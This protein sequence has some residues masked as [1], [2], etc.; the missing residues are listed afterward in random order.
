MNTSGWPRILLALLC[1]LAL[2]TSA[3]AECAWVLWQH[4]IR[5]EPQPQPL[6]TTPISAYA[7]KDECEQAGRQEVQAAVAQGNRSS[8]HGLGVRIADVIA[9]YRCLP[10]PWTR[11]GRREGGRTIG[12]QTKGRPGVPGRARSGRLLE[13]SAPVKEVGTDAGGL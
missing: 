13:P 8:S 5:V 2:A 9:E 11:V 7:S 3:S 6:G 10:T 12:N 4:T 1:L